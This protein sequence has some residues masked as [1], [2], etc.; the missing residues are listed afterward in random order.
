M[1]QIVPFHI[2]I[3]EQDVTVLPT[4]LELTRLPESE[5]CLTPPRH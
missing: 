1:L 5:T 3:P 2:D 4:W